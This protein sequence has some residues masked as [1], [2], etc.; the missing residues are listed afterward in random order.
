MRTTWTVLLLALLALL[1]LTA[2]AKVAKEPTMALQPFSLTQ[3]RLL[4]GPC[5]RM[6]ENNHKYL[7]MLDPDRLLWTFRKQAGLPTP[8]QP[9]GGWE[10]P[11]CEVRGHFVGHYLSALGLMYQSTGDEAVKARADLMVG[12]LA[13]CQQALGGDYL[14]AFP[15]SFFDRL[16]TG[17]NVWVPWYTLHKIMAGLLDV[18]QRCGNAQALQVLLGMVRWAKA[19][20]DKLSDVQLDRVLNVEHGGMNEVLNNLFALTGDP[21]HLALAKRFEHASFIGPL[22][23]D[24]DDLSYIHANT[25]IPKISGAARHYEL[26]GDERY[27]EIARYFWDRIAHHRT[28]CTGGNNVGEGWRE[29]DRLADTLAVNNQE[30]CTVYN[31]LKVTRYLLTWSGDPAYGDYYERNVFNGVLGTQEADGQLMYYVPLASG[32]TRS[33]GQANDSFWCCYGTGIETSSKLGDSIYFHDADSLYVNLF[34]ASTVD[35]ADKGLTIE[36]QTTFPEPSA[37]TIVIKA[38][39]A[40]EVGLKL[41]LPAWTAGATLAINGGAP[42]AV[43]AGGWRGLS[44]VWQVGDK[45]ELKLPMS[46]RTEAMPDDPEKVAPM[47][48]PL[49]LAGLLGPKRLLPI[50]GMASQ[51]SGV[52]APKYVEGEPAQPGDWLKPVEGQPLTWQTAVGGQTVTFEPFYKVTTEPYG[53]YWTVTKPGRPAYERFRAAEAAAAA[54]RAR[55]IDFVQPNDDASERAHNQRGER[56]GHGPLGDSG[57]RD[58]QPGGWFSWDLKVLGDQPLTLSVTYWGSDDGGRSFEVLV[59]DQVVGSEEL[60]ARSPGS[61]FEVT[62]AVPEALTKGKDHV[63]V[64]FRARGNN[65]AG[66][67]FGVATLKPE[68]PH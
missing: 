45:V 18:H 12:E 41:R 21:A 14:S 8:G 54:R 20:T 9:L 65:M 46:L 5:A 33:F 39:P 19:R 2:D 63:T 22:A 36:Q 62:Y 24:H 23:L 64:K 61:T 6:Q 29:P 49:V 53:I 67:V 35:W 26:T 51:L 28:Y 25:N 1:V 48:G 68:A 58:S 4:P 16:E 57:W 59:D 27:A 30:C 17:Q 31:M 60:H 13:K 55:Q 43:E 56:T 3:V 52:K 42:Q 11:D 34:I 38:A 47:A 15:L 7:L 37:T 44:R 40:G 32:Y 50:R 66:G 10:A